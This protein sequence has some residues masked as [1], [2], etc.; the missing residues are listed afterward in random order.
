MK[1]TIEFT[2]ES[3][4][5][6]KALADLSSNQANLCMVCPAAQAL[7]EALAEKFPNSEVGLGFT[8]IHLRPKG[9]SFK[10]GYYYPGREVGTLSDEYV[11]NKTTSEWRNLTL[12]HKLTAVI[13]YDE[14]SPHQD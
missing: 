3:R 2:V 5:V 10:N 14:A 6:D 4:H 8:S 7:G 1:Q 12:P 9:T 13:D 11:T